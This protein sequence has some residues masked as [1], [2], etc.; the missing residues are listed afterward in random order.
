MLQYIQVHH[1]ALQ[2]S[3]DWPSIAI[4]AMSLMMHCCAPAPAPEANCW[5]MWFMNK[6]LGCMT[7]LRNQMLPMFS[8]SDHC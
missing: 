4:C 8:L 3:H 2:M 1:C 7:T 5:M 6:R